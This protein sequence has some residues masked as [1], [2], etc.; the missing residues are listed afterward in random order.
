MCLKVMLLAL[1]V[2]SED[3]IFGE[4]EKL[5]QF[6]IRFMAIMDNSSYRKLWGAILLHPSPFWQRMAAGLAEKVPLNLN[7]IMPA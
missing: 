4:L 5:E 7:R 1:Q 6:V 3:S 2:L